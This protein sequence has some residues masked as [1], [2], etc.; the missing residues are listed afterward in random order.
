MSTNCIPRPNGPPCS[1]VYPVC[2]VSHLRINI[3]SQCFRLNC[4][5]GIGPQMFFSF[6]NHL[7]GHKLRPTWLHYTSPA[8]GHITW[9]AASAAAIQNRNEGDHKE[10]T[11]TAARSSIDCFFLLFLEEMNIRQQCMRVKWPIHVYSKYRALLYRDRRQ[12]VVLEME[13]N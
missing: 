2:Y 9:P 12:G 13:R 3:A 5:L 10:V 1:K 8:R 4:K 7:T 6:R 11:S